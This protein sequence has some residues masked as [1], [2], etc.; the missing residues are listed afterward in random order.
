MEDREAYKG[1][2]AFFAKQVVSGEISLGDAVTSLPTPT[3]IGMDNNL[4]R[5]LMM[6]DAVELEKSI[7]ERQNLGVVK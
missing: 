7:A 4:T 2:L 5:Y 6:E 1:Q 3:G